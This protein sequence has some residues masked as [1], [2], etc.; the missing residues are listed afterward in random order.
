MGISKEAGGRNLISSCRAARLLACILC[1]AVV[2]AFMPAQAHAAGS[3]MKTLK[4]GKTYSLKLDGKTHKVKYTNTVT[5]Q[6]NMSGVFRIYVDG[7]VKYTH[8]NE[9]VSVGGKVRAAKV[10]KKV[11][12]LHI[13]FE[14]ENGYNLVD[15][16][17]RYSGG[18]LKTAANLIAIREGDKKST[19]GAK[20]NSWTRGATVTKAGAGKLTVRFST[21]DNLI[22]IY[23]ATL[24]YKYKGGKAKRVTSEFKPKFSSSSGWKGNTG[25]IAVAF[26]VYT[27][28]GGSVVS[29][30]ANKG[31][32]VK[33]LKVKLVKGTRWFYLQDA[34]G[35]KGWKKE[36]ESVPQADPWKWFEEAWFAA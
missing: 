4:Q 36:P 11:T 15:R 27:K 32:R 34:A 6:A 9:A 22:G 5:D 2:F 13:K 8:K 31:D 33:V 25:T 7:K 21:S 18:K 10:S 14:G 12:L 20:L 24:T 35:K 28:L 19:K 17:V 30:R 26:D 23:D 16:L 3:G 29:F 1:A